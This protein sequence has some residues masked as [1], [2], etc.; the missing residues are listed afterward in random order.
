M[1]SRASILVVDDNI[2]DRKTLS[3]FLSPL[4]YEIRC[5]A[6][7]PEALVAAEADPP[8]LII[9]DVVLPEM[10][11]FEVCER[12]KSSPETTDIPVLCTTGL[13]SIDANERALEC[14]A[15]GFLMKPLNKVLVEAYAKAFVRMK[16]I[17]DE[18]KN[19]L[20]F[21]VHD[22]RSPVTALKGALA[23][24]DR[25]ATDETLHKY[26][27]IAL[28]SANRL[29]LLIDS[30]L[31][32]YKMESGALQVHRQPVRLDEVVHKVVAELD[33]LSERKNAPIQAQVDEELTAVVD[34]VLVA[35][36]IQNLLDNAL[37][38]GRSNHPI[39]LTASRSDGRVALTVANVCEAL[40]APEL[41][42]IFD[43][44]AQAELSEQGKR[45]GSGLGLPFCKMVAEAHGG[46]LEA[47][48]PMPGRDDGI[49]FCLDLPAEAPSG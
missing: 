26:T 2:L 1:K 22:M 32:L 15:E 16:Q 49:M 25:L 9:L 41:V 48:S 35:R 21:V 31:D 10:D 12:L 46:S 23:I 4:G 19:L 18:R 39:D 40:S 17:N 28:N 14:G 33:S 7:G 6:S 42:R 47:V 20:H 44:F 29:M 30:M 38:Y 27:D 5:V 36:L 37:R 45:Q 43:K 13:T 34:P 24:L 3:A 8:D 11:G